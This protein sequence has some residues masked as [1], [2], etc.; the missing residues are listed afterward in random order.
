MLI[1]ESLILLICILILNSLL[2]NRE[3]RAI[4]IRAL[5]AIDLFLNILCATY[6]HE[7]ALTGLTHHR[8]LVPFTVL[9][10][11]QLLIDL[12]EYIY[13]VSLIISVHEWRLHDLALIYSIKSLIHQILLFMLLLFCILIGLWVSFLYFFL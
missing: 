10:G 4:T 11:E 9:L 2:L 8:R 6:H 13:V 12:F 5:F 7:V 1:K 3:K